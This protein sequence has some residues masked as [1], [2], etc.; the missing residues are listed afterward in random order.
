MKLFHLFADRKT[1][2]E[3]DWATYQRYLKYYGSKSRAVVLVQKGWMRFHQ[4]GRTFFE[5]SAAQLN[6]LI[7][8]QKNMGGGGNE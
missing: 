6:Q 4:R 8:A 5:I 2:K 3:I 7:E 1:V